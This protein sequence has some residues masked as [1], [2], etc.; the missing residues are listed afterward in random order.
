MTR[1]IRSSTAP[2]T[3][4]RHRGRDLELPEL[5]DTVSPV[6]VRL[7]RSS[8]EAMKDEA[9]WLTRR[10]NLECGGFL[11]AEVARSWHREINIVHATTTGHDAV[12]RNSSLTMD[13]TRFEDAQRW[14]AGNGWG[15]LAVCGHFHTHCD[16]TGKDAG[17][18]SGHDLR[19]FLSIRD[20]AHKT[21]GAAFSAGLILTMR[22]IG[23]YMPEH[24][25]ATPTSP[26]G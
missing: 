17:L 13:I 22:R 6:T 4:A 11:F 9:F 24:I 7:S 14:L 25:W 18:P 5:R 19:A 21:R 20:Y 12:R 8:R 15:D 1:I 16:L 23:G 2:A 3:V 10:D 26:R